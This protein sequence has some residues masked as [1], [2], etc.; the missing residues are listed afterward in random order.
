M[1]FEFFSVGWK[2]CKVCGAHTQGQ[3]RLEFEIQVVPSPALC[4]LSSVQPV[5]D[6][7]Q[8]ITS[9]SKV[10]QHCLSTLPLQ[11]IQN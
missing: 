2:L 7:N 8:A 9:S 1:G 5:S 3:L 11:N 6:P 4:S 10:R